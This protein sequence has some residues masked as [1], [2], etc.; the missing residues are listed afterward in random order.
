MHVQAK[1]SWEMDPPEKLEQSEISKN[2]GTDYFKARLIL[3]LK[4]VQYIALLL[5][6]VVDASGSA[7][8]LLIV[9]ICQEFSQC[10]DV[11]VSGRTS[12]L[13]PAVPRVPS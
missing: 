10:I 11:T 2:K 7:D 13:P 4:S 1:E 12:I 9:R 5:H 3:S 8:A 6:Y